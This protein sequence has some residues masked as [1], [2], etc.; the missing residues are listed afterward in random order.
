M[1][2]CVEIASLMLLA[3]LSG[4]AAERRIQE[5]P[6]QVASGDTYASFARVLI[7]SGPSPQM[8]K[9]A[10]SVFGWLIGDWEADVYDYE[11]NGSPWVGKGEWHFS[12]VLEGRAVQD[13]WIVP[14]LADRTA[15]TPTDHNRYGSTLRIYDPKIDAWRVFWFN[16]ARQG[17]AEIVARKVGN[18]IV[19]QGV[20]DDGSFVRWTFTNIRPDSFVW[21]GESSTDGGKTW[22]LGARFVARRVGREGH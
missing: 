21:L 10:T 19:Q 20:D 18:D 15:A 8:P 6:A 4:Q 16:P 22:Q 11:S 12:W 5:E 3:C 14:K 17:R 9:S 13:V 1:R 2:E 7:S